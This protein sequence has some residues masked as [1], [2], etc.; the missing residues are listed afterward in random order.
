VLISTLCGLGIGIPKDRMNRLFRSFSQ[1]DSSTTRTYGGTGLGLAISRRLA[2]LMGGSMWCESDFGKGSTFHFTIKMRA[3]PEV[4]QDSVAESLEILQRK[5]VLIVDD[6]ETN[7][8]ILQNFCESWGMVAH[9]VPDGYAALEYLDHHENIDLA[10]L[11][12][13]MDVSDS[14]CSRDCLV[15]WCLKSSLFFC[16]FLLASLWMVSPWPRGK[17]T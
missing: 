7:R 9:G 16:V 1:V 8:F 13:Q 5:R 2:E 6:N 15:P 14:H 3:A 10:L 17:H 11:D 4:S 12:M